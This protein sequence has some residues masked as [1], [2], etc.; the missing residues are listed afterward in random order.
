MVDTTSNSLFFYSAIISFRAIS[1]V[2]VF[3]ERFILAARANSRLTTTLRNVSAGYRRGNLALGSCA[4][5]TD[6]RVI[7]CVRKARCRLGNSR[8]LRRTVMHSLTTRENERKSERIRRE[9]EWKEGEWERERERERKY[10]L[11]GWAREVFQ[12]CWYI[13]YFTI[14]NYGLLLT[15]S[16]TLSDDPTVFTIPRD[17][18]ETSRGDLIERVPHFEKQMKGKA[19]TKGWTFWFNEMCR[20]HRINNAF[21]CKGEN[22]WKRT[23]EKI[24]TKSYR[25][26]KRG[27]A[28]ITRA[29]RPRY[30]GGRR[31]AYLKNDRVVHP[32]ICEMENDFLENEHFF[33][34]YLRKLR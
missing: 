16:Q 21:E 23:R 31:N 10:C 26:P 9:K 30:T 5:V 20:I 2:V 18:V 24:T 7:M 13:S 3:I 4:Y 17:G 15:I 33:A 25:F 8:V 1:N 11:I 29:K 34:C 27:G 22:L 28:W 19:R 6:V 14:S 12:I 32:C